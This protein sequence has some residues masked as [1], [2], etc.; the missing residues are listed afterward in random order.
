MPPATG[1]RS[2]KEATHVRPFERITPA[3]RFVAERGR[4]AKGED[5]VW[6]DHD[7]SLSMQRVQTSNP[8]ERR[9]ERL[10]SPTAADNRISDGGIDVP[11]AFYD[12]WVAAL[13]EHG[14]PVVYILPELK[15]TERIFGPP[16]RLRS[17]PM[18]SSDAAWFTHLG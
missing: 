13:A 1:E 15:S 10:A 6:I 12:A 18:A 17:V 14:R 4:N 8:A 7:A 11:A 16:S 5:I 2:I 3:G 9:L